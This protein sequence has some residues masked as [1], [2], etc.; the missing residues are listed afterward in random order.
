ECKLSASICRN[1]V[2]FCELKIK[3]AYKIL[4]V[5]AIKVG[6]SNFFDVGFVDVFLNHYKVINDVKCLVKL[7]IRFSSF[8]DY[9]GFE[10]MVLSRDWVILNRSRSLPMRF[11]LPERP[12]TLCRQGAR[13][14]RDERSAPH[15]VV[16]RCK[17]IEGLFIGSM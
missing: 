1:K 2:Y 12:T 10:D 17:A 16:D 14:A 13:S 9:L 3:D 11:V 4:D 15:L 6:I 8:D 7:V 5:S